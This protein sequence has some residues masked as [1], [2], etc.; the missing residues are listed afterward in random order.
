MICIK[1]YRRNSAT[2]AAGQEY[3]IDAETA[4]ADEA[5]FGCALWEG[6]G[7]AAKAAEPAAAEAPKPKAKGK[8]RGKR[9]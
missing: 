7:K 1:D 2:Y 4:A 8:A 3:D 9:K 5:Y 6:K